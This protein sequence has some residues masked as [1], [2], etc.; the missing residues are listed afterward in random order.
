[1]TVAP[2]AAP[3]PMYKPYR[4]TIVNF[5]FAKTKQKQQ[6]WIRFLVVEE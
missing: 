3:T 2:E 1:M 5:G 6:A 4:A